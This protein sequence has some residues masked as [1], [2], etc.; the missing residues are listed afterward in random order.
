MVDVPGDVDDCVLMYGH[1]DKQPSSR[2]G[3]RISRRDSGPARRK[4]LRAAARTTATPSSPRSRGPHPARAGVPHARCVVLIEAARKVAPRPLPPHRRAGR[5]PR[6]PT[7]VV[8]LDASA[9]ITSSCGC[10]TSLRG[11]LI[12]SLRVTCCPKRALRYRERRR[13]VELPHPART[14]GTRGGC[15]FGDDTDRGTQRADSARP[16]V[17]AKAAAAVLGESVYTKSR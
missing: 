6:R 16:L 17:Q 5:P 2:A 10:T 4:A 9:A 11:N 15:H 3:P 12:G 14:A 7:L 13:A 8:C 1:L